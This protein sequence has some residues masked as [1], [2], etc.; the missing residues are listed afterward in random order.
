MARPRDLVLIAGKGHETTQTFRDTVVPFDDGM[1][2]R[3]ALR[4]RADGDDLPR[5]DSIRRGSARRLRAE[6]VAS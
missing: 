4:R 2:A 6:V 1:I 3:E 5:G